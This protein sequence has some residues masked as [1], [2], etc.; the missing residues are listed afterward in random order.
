VAAAIDNRGEARTWLIPDCFEKF[1]DGTT[2]LQGE[3][4]ELDQLGVVL[5]ESCDDGGGKALGTKALAVVDKRRTSDRMPIFIAMRS[6]SSRLQI[7]GKCVCAIPRYCL[8]S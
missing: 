3:R 4:G 2:N 8:R 5:M 6:S 7:D 1:L